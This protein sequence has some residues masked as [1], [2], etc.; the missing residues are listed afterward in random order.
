MIEKELGFKK[1]FVSCCFSG[2]AVNIGP[3]MIGIYYFGNEI[4]DLAT[5]KDI[6]TKLNSK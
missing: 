6:I 4:T 5:E 2:N 1:V 3:G